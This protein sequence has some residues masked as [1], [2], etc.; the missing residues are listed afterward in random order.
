MAHITNS[1]RPQYFFYTIEPLVSMRN[2]SDDTA[3]VVSQ[4]FLS[5][6]VTQRRKSNGFTYIKTQDDSFGWVPSNC[7]S[8]RN[9]AYHTAIKVSQ[10]SAPIYKKNSTKDVAIMKLPYGC[11]LQVLSKS[12]A[13]WT[14]VALPNGKEAYVKNKDIEPEPTLQSKE[15]LVQFSQKFVGVPYLKG[16]RS[17]FGFDNSGFIQMLYS[18]IGISL[19]R[20]VK[21]QAQAPEFKEISFESIKPGDLVFFENPKK[22]ITHCAMYLGDRKV[23]HAVENKMVTI[24]SLSK[25]TFSCIRARQLIIS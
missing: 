3:E 23:I 14:K 11:K 6:Q 5:E 13:T 16:G 15:D 8:W 10:L 4:T 22:E 21:D 17:S 12:D 9:E 24:S 7:I 19:P 2:A 18:Q 1:T 20:G 25:I